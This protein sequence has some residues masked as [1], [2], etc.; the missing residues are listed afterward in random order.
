MHI[1]QKSPIFNSSP[2][3][4]W[5]L[6]KHI[7]TIACDLTLSKLA[8]ESSICFCWLLPR[9]CLYV[10]NTAHCW[11]TTSP[12]VNGTHFYHIITMMIRKILPEQHSEFAKHQTMGGWSTHT[13]TFG[14]HT[15]THRWLSFFQRQATQVG[16]S[17]SNTG[18]AASRRQA[19]Q[20]N[21]ELK[22]R[23]PGLGWPLRSV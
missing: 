20:R 15:H 21:F 1:S 13:T 5:S 22:S 12:L 6:E 17:Y 16:F 2:T 7:L 18:G 9:G 14:H 10:W 3:S 11:P 23:L 8:N 19:M 4:I